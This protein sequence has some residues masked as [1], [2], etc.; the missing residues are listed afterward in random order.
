MKGKEKKGKERKGNESN[1]FIYV[2]ENGKN[3]KEKN[4][5]EKKGNG[6]LSSAFHPN[7]GGKFWKEK[8]KKEKE[9]RD[10]EKCGVGWGGEVAV[11]KYLDQDS[12]GAVFAEFKRERSSTPSS[13]SAKV[14]VP[15]VFP[16]LEIYDFR[17][18]NSAKLNRYF[19]LAV[20]HVG[21]PRWFSTPVFPHRFS[22]PVFHVEVFP[23]RG[24]VRREASLKGSEKA[25]SYMRDQ[26]WTSDRWSLVLVYLSYGGRIKPKTEFRDTTRDVGASGSVRSTHFESCTVVPGQSAPE[27]L[28]MHEFNI[29][30]PD[31]LEVIFSFKMRLMSYTVIPFYSPDESLRLI[32][33]K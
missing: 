9:E 6:F 33:G 7:V 27:G 18:G 17:V 13:F 4:G 26:L 23:R 29:R 16:E 21:F 22:T 25:Q 31:D 3:G 8:K 20:F 14:L 12:S 15:N 32:M 5:K 10:R 2:L 28:N 11:K 24:E 1:I 19:D 30:C